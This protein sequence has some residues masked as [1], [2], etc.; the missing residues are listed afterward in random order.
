MGISHSINRRLSPMEKSQWLA[1]QQC[2]SN[3]LSHAHFIGPLN[4]AILQKALD[5]LQARHPLLR[6]RIAREGRNNAKFISD[7]APTIPIRLARS[8]SGKWTE[9]AERELNTRFSAE[10]AP[11]MRCVLIQH[12]NEQHTVLLSFHHAIGDGLSGAYLMR[13]LF[14]SADAILGG[15]NPSLPPME[16][17]KA[18]ETYFP[19][20][21]KGARGR[22]VHLG[23]M[24]NYIGLELKRERPACLKRDGWA[25]FEKRSVHIHALK[26]QGSVLEKL[27]LRAKHY[28]TTV[29]GAMLAAM[30]LAMARDLDLKNPGLFSVGSPVN[31]RKHL[32]PLIGDDVGFFVAMGFST[33]SAKRDTAFWPLARNTRQ[34]LYQCV[35]KGIPLVLDYFHKDLD[36]IPMVFGTGRM[37]ARI[38]SAI[39]NKM[40]K[41]MPGFSNIGRLSFLMSTKRLQIDSIGFAASGSVMTNLATFAATAGDL[42]TWNFVGMAPLYTR[43]HIQKIARD[44]LDIL[45]AQAN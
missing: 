3:F 44:S 11:L 33:N 42:T 8:I 32:Q 22:L 18:M 21:V 24:A 27:H 26:I 19:N 16:P 45:E 14:S 10:R 41:S 13:D 40:T 1:D 31:L 35:E 23:F 5:V 9:D 15:K 36:I 12:D 7:S 28:R 25:P 34:F 4:E 6:V 43:K 20:W 29:H 30:I 2:C 38:Y 39:L 17:M 37:G